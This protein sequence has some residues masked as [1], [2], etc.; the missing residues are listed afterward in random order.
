[1][2]HFNFLDDCMNII[3]YKNDTYLSHLDNN[4]LKTINN[5]RLTN[6]ITHND[7]EYLLGYYDITF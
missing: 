2:K 7:I 6:Q 3:F 1:M 5:I 4:I